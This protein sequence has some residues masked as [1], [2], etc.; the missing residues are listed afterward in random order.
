[1][2]ILEKLSSAQIKTVLKQGDIKIK[3]PQGFVTQKKKR[4]IWFSKILGALEQHNTQVAE[5]LLQ[6]WFLNHRRTML[7]EYLDS[8]SVKHSNGETDDNFLITRDGETVKKH[9]KEL[10]AKFD[11]SDVVGYLHYVAYQQKAT[12]FEDWDVLSA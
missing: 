11:R 2:E 5:E 10:L 1:M 6:Q 3:N 9:A 7:I 12:V 8:L 4:E